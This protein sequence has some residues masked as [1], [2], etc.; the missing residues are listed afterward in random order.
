MAPPPHYSP[1]ADPSPALRRP[2][3]R[4]KA[5][6]SASSC[7]NE[8]PGGIGKAAAADCAQMITKCII[9]RTRQS[10][11]L[12]SVSERRAAI[13]HRT[14]VTGGGGG[15]RRLRRRRRYSTTTVRRRRRWRRKETTRERRRLER[16]VTLSVRY[17][18]GFRTKLNSFSAASEAS[19]N[20]LNRPRSRVR[21]LTFLFFRVAFFFLPT[22]TVS[23]IRPRVWT[24]ILDSE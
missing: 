7:T 18:R 19:E 21:K 12:L 23:S 8:R 3:R 17:A 13:T 10:V 16:V 22:E 5:V 24:F 6:V 11:Q 14:E 1:C 2:H 4:R 20:V 9:T 15:K